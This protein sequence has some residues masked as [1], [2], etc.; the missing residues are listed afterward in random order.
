MEKNSTNFP[1]L[2]SSFFDEVKILR[3]D[4]PALNNLY[5]IISSKYKGK[6]LHYL[7]LNKE[8]FR[9]I[10][11]LIL[12]QYYLKVPQEFDIIKPNYVF[13]LYSK[14]LKI[15]ETSYDEF[16]ERNQNINYPIEGLPYRIDNSQENLVSLYNNYGSC[17][18]Y[19]LFYLDKN[20][21]TLKDY[22][23]YTEEGKKCR[24]WSYPLFSIKTYRIS[25]EHYPHMYENN[26]SYE[27]SNILYEIRGLINHLNNFRN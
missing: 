21:S 3:G 10:L 13:V 2:R 25:N 4:I 22:F 6:N 17:L 11:R 9:D 18:E 19:S 24:R 12:I 26:S 1:D 5:Q 15:T 27:N 20:Y 8:T 14:T 23:F 16:V 7:N